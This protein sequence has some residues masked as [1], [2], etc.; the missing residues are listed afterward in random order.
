MTNEIA[1]HGDSHEIMSWDEMVGSA[2]AYFIDGLTIVDKPDLLGIPHAI[3]AVRFQRA[4][5]RGAVG[6]K[7][8]RDWI[9]VEATVAPRETLEAEFQ[10]GR[11]PNVAS[12]DALPFKPAERIVYNDGSTGV[13]RQ[14]VALLDNAGLIT[15]G[16][17]STSDDRRLDRRFDTAWPDWEDAGDQ[18]AVSGQD[19]D[20]N[21]VKVP[22]FTR[23][24][25]GGQFLIV[26]RRGLR[27]SNYEYDGT[28]TQT[29]YL[30]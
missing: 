4:E 26:C 15:V 24:H 22:A 29:Y 14:F 28:E 18:W 5:M 8:L 12:I 11:I 1:I 17:T 19:D 23:N 7:V 2:P 25:T 30:Q 16:G 21:D 13:R 20:Q 6:H 27:V 3:T 10:R 9:S